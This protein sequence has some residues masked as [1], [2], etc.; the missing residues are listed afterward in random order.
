MGRPLFSS[1]ARAHETPAVRVEHEPTQ[2]ACERWTYWNPFDPDSEEF[3]LDAEEERVRSL[4][5][6]P[7][8][9][10]VIDDLSGSS[11]ESDGTSSGRETPIFVDGDDAPLVAELSPEEG[12]LAQT[13]GMHNL[14]P[15]DERHTYRAIQ[16]RVSQPPLVLGFSS[17]TATSYVRT[18]Y[19][20]EDRS[21]NQSPSPQSP[22]LTEPIPRAEVAAE[23]LTIPRSILSARSAPVAIPVRPSTPPSQTPW[24][25]GTPSPAPSITP[26]LYTWRAPLS[27]TTS[28]VTPL[29]N[30]TARM[31]VAHISP[32]TIAVQRV[33]G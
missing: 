15:E 10:E 23:P 24:S 12:R 27:V 14:R 22:T 17:R 11:S 19:R 30:R 20:G 33:L 16:A 31:S 9:V 13:A 5:G 4:D 3:F 21:P 28:P 6:P 1:V 25:Y 29:P 2:P 26:R 7:V 32:S 8:E 18:P